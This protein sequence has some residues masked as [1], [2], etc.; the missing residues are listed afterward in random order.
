MA[1]RHLR[2]SFC[3]TYASCIFSFV[4]WSFE[5]L[6]WWF[7]LQVT[8]VKEMLYYSPR[9]CTIS[10]HPVD[11]PV[12]FT[13][14]QHRVVFAFWVNHVLFWSFDKMTRGGKQIG[15]RTIAGRIVKESYGSAKQQHTF[16][17]RLKSKFWE[18]RY[19]WLYNNN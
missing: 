1:S 2:I 11:S 16:T 8:C 9:K 13:F 18:R 15:K 3:F 6:A 10:I 7:F 4:F 14:F 19:I 17:V 12:C 5:Y